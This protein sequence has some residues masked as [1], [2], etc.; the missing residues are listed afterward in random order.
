MAASRRDDDDDHDL[1]ELCV[2]TTKDLFRR[3]VPLSSLVD[4]NQEAHD[5]GE[6]VSIACAI[7]DLFPHSA[8][9]IPVAFVVIERA[10]RVSA[11]RGLDGNA[12]ELSI[13]SSLA[14]MN[15]LASHRLVWHREDGRWGSA[16][17]RWIEWMEE[18]DEYTH[19]A[20][21]P[22]AKAVCKS[23][24]RLCAPGSQMCDAWKCVGLTDHL[25]HPRG[26]RAPAGTHDQKTVK[27]LLR[28]ARRLLPREAHVGKDSW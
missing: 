12:S 26:T 16:R 5:T 8:L 14:L 1:H 3:M 10:P 23:C 11:T 6:W 27:M 21:R 17:T 20:E 19:A 22:P 9:D 28:T 18:I 15:G 24:K 4:I 25:L 13:V 2:H 7:W